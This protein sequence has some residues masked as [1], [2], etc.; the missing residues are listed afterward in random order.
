[1]IPEHGEHSSPIV[2]NSMRFAAQAAPAHC[3]S[4]QPFNLA[5]AVILLI[6]T[7]SLGFVI[8]SI[9]AVLWNWIHK[10]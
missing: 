8:G 7:L 10:R 3:Y 4:V 5:T 6:V 1:V 2:L 9:F